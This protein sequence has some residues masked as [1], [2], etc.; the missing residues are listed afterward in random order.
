MAKTVQEYYD[1]IK[2]EAL[3]R[4]TSVGNVDFVNMM[5]NTSRVAIWKII[6]WA[7][8]YGAYL[9]AVVLDLFRI[10]TDDKIKRLKPHTLKWWAEKAMTFQY[11]DNLVPEK[12]YYDNTGLTETEIKQRQVVKYAAAIEQFFSNGEFGIRL[13]L[14]G[15]DGSGARIALTTPQ[16]DAFKEFLARY[17]HAG[18]YR[19][20]TTDD[21]DH[22]KLVLR[23][24]YNPLVLTNTGARIDGFSATPLQDAI[25]AHTKNLPFN[26]RFNLT[27]LVDAMQ[28]VDGVSDPRILSAQTQYA[29]LPYTN[30]NDEVIPDAGYLKIYDLNTDLT[31]TWIAKSAV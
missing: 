24:Y 13:K 6:F 11:G 27:A 9:I 3:S 18:V 4:A 19:E 7:A 21:A 16:L 22:L 1:E 20:A 8:A 29:A 14:A 12:D 17:R 26:G 10:E 15:E 25:D 2:A 28:A 31:I 23:V 30:V 5:N